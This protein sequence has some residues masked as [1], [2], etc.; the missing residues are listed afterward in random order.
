M[1]A[2]EDQ[3]VQRIAKALAFKSGARLALGIGDDLAGNEASVE[4]KAVP[5]RRETMPQ[6]VE[7]QR[8]SNAV[9]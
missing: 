9:V 7:S 3:L 6:H 5:A 4:I 2:G 8:N 1:K